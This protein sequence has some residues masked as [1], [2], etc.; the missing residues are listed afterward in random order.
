MDQPLT[1]LPS[2]AA[3]LESPPC[4]VKLLGKRLAVAEI[5]HPK[6][7][8]A[9]MQVHRSHWVAHAALTGLWRAREGWRLRLQG[10]QE[11]P[12]ARNRATAVKDWACSVLTAS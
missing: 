5:R 10:G 8:A 9:G 11:V 12:V 3:N 6:A 1:E 7:E 4:R 2:G